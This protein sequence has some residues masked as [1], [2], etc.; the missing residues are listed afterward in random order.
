MTWTQSFMIWSERTKLVKVSFILYFS[1][2]LYSFEEDNFWGRKGREEWCRIKWQNTIADFFVLPWF[3]RS[4]SFEPVRAFHVC[5]SP[6]FQLPSFFLFF[7]FFFAIIFYKKLILAGSGY[8]REKK[9]LKICH[10]LFFFKEEHWIRKEMIYFN[11]WNKI[12]EVFLP[13]KLE[14]RQTFACFI[15]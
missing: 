6:L 13:K 14:Q 12:Q 3:V 2:I 5:P 15:Q 9:Y 7:F 4:I 1:F 11:E 8:T 10:S